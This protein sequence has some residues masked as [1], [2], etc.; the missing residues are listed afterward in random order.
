MDTRVLGYQLYSA[1]ED[2]RITKECL[3]AKCSVT[4]A[5]LCQIE[6]GKR[7]PSLSLFVEVC[8]KLQEYSADTPRG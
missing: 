6:Q 7:V 1:R 8:N 5:H 3:A 4:P 2:R